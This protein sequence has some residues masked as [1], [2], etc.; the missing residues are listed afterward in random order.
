[1]NAIAR[2]FRMGKRFHRPFRKMI[3]RLRYFSF[4]LQMQKYSDQVTVGKNVQIYQKIVFQGKGKI[5]LKDGVILGFELGG[6]PTLPILLQPRD[7]EA[8]IEIGAGSILANGT[9]IIA[10]KHVSIG[11]ACRIGAR[12][13]ILDADFH[14]LKPVERD[15]GGK[16]LPITIGNQVWLGR[17][18]TILKGVTIGDDAIVGAGSVVAKNVPPGGI[19][20]GNPIKIIGSV[21]DK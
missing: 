4:W 13:V 2:L 21:Y 10:R 15:K 18:V 3:G 19:A 12:C 6:S 14:G 17:G 1:M 16:V 7:S 20:V 9:E 8:V 5:Y 11:K